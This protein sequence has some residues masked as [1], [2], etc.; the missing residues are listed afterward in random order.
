M[1]VWLAE[2]LTQYFSFFNV[3]SYLT[4]RS[5]LGILT[6]LLLSLYLGP[7]LIARLQRMQIGQVVRGDGPESHFSKKGTPTM[8]G[9]LILGA[10][11]VSTLLWANLENKY[12]WV[13]LFVLVSFGWIGFVDDYRKVVRKDP[14]GL[15]ARWKYFWQSLFAIITAA[16]L[17]LTAERPAETALLVPFLKDVMPQ[18]GLLF[19]A[20]SYFV[21]VGTSNAVNLTD[22][23]DGL[24]I[25]PTIMVA[26]AFAIIAY[27]SGNVNFSAYLNIPYLPHASELVVFLAALIGAG[28][29]FLWFNT[30]PAQV[31]MGDVGSLALGAVLG[32]VAILVRQE[33]VL[34]IMG[35]IF[36]METLSVIL[37]VGSYK[38]RG[39]RIFRMAPIHHHYE[40]KGWP[41]PRVIVRFWILSI[42][43][44]LVGLATLK[45][46]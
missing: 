28:L 2:Y 18:L 3:F 19:L 5:I 20:L 1:L 44:V 26:G 32:V 42:I 34:F 45:L 4:F 39:Q 30:Y 38:L 11:L 9:L 37:Q 43:F 21:I 23:L 7:K 10:V 15:I 36:V 8:G 24:A 12:V 31:F 22:G 35:G 13:V 14:K 29:G 33:I 40:L 17:Y 16:F 27:V 46:R 25:V 6:S 41:E